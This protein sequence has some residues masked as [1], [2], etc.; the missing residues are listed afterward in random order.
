M[1]LSELVAALPVNHSKAQCVY[2]LMRILVHSG[3]FTE[4][5]LSENAKEEQD[6]YLL[7][8]ASRLLLKDEPLSVT[9][10]LLAMLDPILTKPWHHVS[11]WFQNGDPT[12]FGTAHGRTLWEYGRHEPR[13]N[14][15]FNEAMASDARLVAKVLVKD[16][17]GVFEGLHS[18]VD[19]GG[20]TARWAKAILDAFPNLK[21]TVLDLPHVVSACKG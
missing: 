20:G 11:E 13:L 17:K 2:R 6:G 18:L 8:P 1:P 14:H 19:V 15:F 21:C 16:W 5:K 12:P 10:F 9:P 4:E 7:T 3:F